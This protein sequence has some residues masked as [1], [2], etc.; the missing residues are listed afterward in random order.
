M[1]RVQRHRRRSACVQVAG[2]ADL[3]VDI[4]LAQFGQQSRC[5]RARLGDQVGQPHA[6]AYSLRAQPR[7][8]QHTPADVGLAGMQRQAQPGRA[9][10]CQ[11]VGVARCR[12]AGFRA[13]QVEAQHPSR[14]WFG[15]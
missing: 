13:G 1:D 8:F 6:V 5:G 15:R 9:Q 14:A 11:Q 4:A 2:R 3:Q 7:G 10:P 12:P